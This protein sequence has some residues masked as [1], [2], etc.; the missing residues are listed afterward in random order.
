M[1]LKE[2]VRKIFISWSSVSHGCLFKCPHLLA[3]CHLPC[4]HCHRLHLLAAPYNAN[5]EA[6]KS[7]CLIY[8]GHADFFE[9]HVLNTQ[10]KRVL[11]SWNVCRRTVATTDS[12]LQ[13]PGNDFGQQHSTYRFP[14]NKTKLGKGGSKI[15]NIDSTLDNCRY[16]Y[17]T[18][19][20]RFGNT[21]RN[22]TKLL[23]WQPYEFKF[24]DSSMPNVREEFVLHSR[25]VRDTVSTDMVWISR[26]NL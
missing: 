1:E 13:V 25:N 20:G 12:N 11:N 3:T 14:E 17:S 10:A 8:S 24:R 2:T 23:D 16:I 7:L 9:V 26:V 22:T 6:S 21:V 5:R 15:D 4:R 18:A 19:H